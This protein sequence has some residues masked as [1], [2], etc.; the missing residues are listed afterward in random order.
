MKTPRRTI[1]SR[2]KD[3]TI[4]IVKVLGSELLPKRFVGDVE[5][6]S[7]GPRDPLTKKWQS[8]LHLQ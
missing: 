2:D 8:V 4:F 5:I 7:G 1:N 6:G 3:D